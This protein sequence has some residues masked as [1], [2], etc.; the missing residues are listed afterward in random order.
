MSFAAW[1]FEPSANKRFADHEVLFQGLLQLEQAAVVYLQLQSRPFVRKIIRGFGLSDDLVEEVLNKSTLIFLKK[2]E[3]GKYQFQ[4]NAPSTYLIE[5][6]KR[7]ALMETRNTGQMAESLDQHKDIADPE[8]EVLLQRSES[9]EL[10][11]QF[12]DQLGE[13]CKTVI[14][15]YHIEGYSD[16][17]VINQKLTRYTT[18]DSLKMKRSDCMKKLIQIARQWKISNNT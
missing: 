12:L 9:A 6:A 14:R 5:V 8:S 2:I 3:Q 16:E 10:V 11:A 4:G 17:E 13:P 7:V 18:V 1:F 15:L